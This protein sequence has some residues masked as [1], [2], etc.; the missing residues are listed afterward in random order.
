VASRGKTTAFGRDQGRQRQITATGAGS[1]DAVGPQSET[2]TS[3]PIGA[4]TAEDS[5]SRS[6]LRLEGDSPGR[7]QP[8]AGPGIVNFGAGEPDLDIS[9]RLSST[10]SFLPALGTHRLPKRSKATPPGV[11][12][13]APKIT[14]LGVQIL[15]EPGASPTETG[16]GRDAATRPLAWSGTRPPC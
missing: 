6:G 16:G 12:M 13:A 10:T 3:A 1:C 2:G 15:Q 11:L 8:R 7:V 4:Q 5:G 9:A 14:T